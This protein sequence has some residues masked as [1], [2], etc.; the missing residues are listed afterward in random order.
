MTSVHSPDRV[1][2][3][4]KG[5][6]AGVAAAMPLKSGVFGGGAGICQALKCVRQASLPDIGQKC[7]QQKIM[8]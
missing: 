2:E 4:T 3:A 5:F 1:N 6:G 7:I 8:M